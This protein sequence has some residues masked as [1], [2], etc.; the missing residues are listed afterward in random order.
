[1]I[2]DFEFMH[3]KLFPHS[4]PRLHIPTN[5]KKEMSFIP[6]LKWFE[7]QMNDTVIQILRHISLFSKQIAFL[8]LHLF[9]ML[10]ILNLYSI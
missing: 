4:R 5:I 3:D 8:S 10:F 6:P 1:M 9:W 7:K 2:L